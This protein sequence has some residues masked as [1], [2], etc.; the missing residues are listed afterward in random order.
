MHIFLHQSPCTISMHYLHALSPCTIWNIFADI[1]ICTDMD[2]YWLI[3][4]DIYIWTDT[5]IWTDI[6]RYWRY[7]QI[8][9]YVQILIQV[10]GYKLIC[11]DMYRY[12]HICTDIGLILTDM[13]GFLQHMHRYGHIWVDPGL[14]LGWSGNL[15]MIL[16]DTT[17]WTDIHIWTDM[18]LYKQI[19]TYVQI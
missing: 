4:T 17:T 8:H 16:T 2:R 19:H 18:H 7:K 6:D 13:S 1:D 15:L 3:L 14:I 9:T 5:Y 12:K 11:T 10:F